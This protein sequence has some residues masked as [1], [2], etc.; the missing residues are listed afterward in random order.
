MFCDQ[1]SAGGGFC[2]LIKQLQAWGER[3][4]TTW[5][6]QT[7]PAASQGTTQLLIEGTVLHVQYRAGHRALAVIVSLPHPPIGAF[8]PRGC[9][10]PTTHGDLL[11]VAG[12]DVADVW[13]LLEVLPGL[14]QEV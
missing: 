5:V 2:G 9:K 3:K 8:H 6:F 10:G 12:G 13:Q 11:A 7:D 14:M 1:S 4:K